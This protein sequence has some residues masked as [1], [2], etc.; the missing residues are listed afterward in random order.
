[1]DN[2][3]NVCL[4]CGK[5]IDESKSFCSIDCEN[6]YEAWINDRTWL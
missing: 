5:I 4:G 3:Y 2:E 6:K 1:M